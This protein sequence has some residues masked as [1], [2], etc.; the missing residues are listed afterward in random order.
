MTKLERAALKDVNR[1]RK[2][3]GRKPLKRLPKGNPHGE[4]SCPIANA[5]DSGKV[6][7]G[8]D[9]CIVIPAKR[10]TAYLKAG[11]RLV[12]DET[13]TL[14]IPT[15]FDKFVRWFDEQDDEEARKLA[16]PL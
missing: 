14:T 2:A 4:Y 3:E 15:S 11:M 9:N 8:V 6:G 16:L 1:I 7:I 5:L 10:L 13:I 12:P